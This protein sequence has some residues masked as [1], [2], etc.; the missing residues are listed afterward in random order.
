MESKGVEMDSNHRASLIWAYL[1]PEINK[2]NVAMQKFL[3]HFQVTSFLDLASTDMPVKV[4]S[5]KA[6]FL[7]M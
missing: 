7:I 2:I 3:S 1:R 6:L 5:L 4:H